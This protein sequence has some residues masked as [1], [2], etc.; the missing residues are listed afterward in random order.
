MF[1]VRFLESYGTAFQQFVSKILELRFPDDFT[2]VRP[3]GPEGDWKCDGLLK[4]QRRFLQA[5]GPQN[6]TKR[7]VLN[8]INEDYMGA[9][10]LWHNTFDTWTFVHNRRDGLPPYAIARLQEL[11][12]D[13]SDVHE[14]DEWGYAK[15]RSLTFE[16]N[17]DQL[18]DLLG[19]PVYQSD[20]L[21][22]EIRDI[23]PLLRRIEISEPAPLDKVRPVPS[24]KLERNYLSEDAGDLLRAGMRRADEVAAYFAM[25]TMRPMFRDDLAERFKLKYEQLKSAELDPDAILSELI[26][27]LTGTNREPTPQA[28]A[29]AIIAYFFEQCD[30]FEDPSRTGT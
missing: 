17:E 27:W 16:L 15:L 25:Q 24:D 11:S 2:P 14:C 9:V 10:Q 22:T 28:A 19:L 5:Y 12:D 26:N 30:I 29:L 23:I 8:K 1:K 7:Q 4:S 21:S 6:F 18:T 20:I 3:A 13:P